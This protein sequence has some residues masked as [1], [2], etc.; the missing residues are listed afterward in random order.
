MSTSAVT[1][2]IKCIKVGWKH[3]YYEEDVYF[4]QKGAE[5]G[6][7]K[8]QLQSNNLYHVEDVIKLA[9]AQF[10]NPK[11]VEFLNQSTVRFGW[12]N[13]EHI[14]E[15]FNSCNKKVGIFS[16]FAINNYPLTKHL[17]LLSTHDENYL[18]DTTT[19]EQ[20]CASEQENLLNNTISTSTKNLMN[21]EGQNNTNNRI[22][23]DCTQNK[24]NLL[25]KYQEMPQQDCIM[26]LRPITSLI[27]EHSQMDLIVVASEKLKDLYYNR[28][29]VSYWHTSTSKYS[30]EI[31][32]TECTK[33]DIF[34]RVL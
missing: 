7:K 21:I 4:Q 34:L 9:K 1:S 32:A 14:P 22:L 12:F 23:Q 27:N 19:Y 26:K 5:G 29:Q 13:G 28:A 8:L 24:V 33:K 18:S 16:Y 20:H 6:I 3:R 2:P 17:Y 30:G 25:S 11:A 15:F 10:K 31:F